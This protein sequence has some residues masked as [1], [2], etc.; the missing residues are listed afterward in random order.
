MNPTAA[1]A[2]RQLLLGAGVD[3]NRIAGRALPRQ[4][5]RIDA[6]ETARTRRPLTR[7]GARRGPLTEPQMAAMRESLER[8]A[9]LETDRVERVAAVGRVAIAAYD[10]GIRDAVREALT[11]LDAG[12][13][14][15]C[16]KCGD[17]IPVVRLEEV[18][19]ARRCR[20]CQEREE[21][22]WNNLERMVAGV[23]RSLAGE[24]QGKSE[25]KS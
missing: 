23:V 5:I 21:N 20:A 8:L 22:S 15:N 24:P 13:Y 9:M 6:D 16:E 25:A 12:T 1:G 3:R 19:Y 4:T 2:S 17:P 11:K 18:P 7:A 10:M 14:G